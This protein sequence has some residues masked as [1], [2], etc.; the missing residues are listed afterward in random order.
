MT[1]V[2]IDNAFRQE[3]CVQSAKKAESVLSMVIK[4]GHYT[5]VVDK[6]DFRVLYKTYVPP[7]LEY[8]VTLTLNVYKQFDE[9][10]RSWSKD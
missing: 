3:Q 8:C 4:K 6:E 7:H 10:Q 5:K 2:R 1:V 9:W